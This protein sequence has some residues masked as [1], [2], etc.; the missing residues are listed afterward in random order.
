MMKRGKICPVCKKDIGQ[1]ADVCP[2]CGFDQ[3]NRI[4]LSKEDY[5]DWQK[6]K[7]SSQEKPKKETRLDVVQIKED[8]L[9]PLF[10]APSGSPGGY[11][12]C[13]RPGT[14]SDRAYRSREKQN[15]T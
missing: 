10:S 8:V 9:P 3:M 1:E 13:A 11:A 14:P 12:R 6:E 15:P 4:F 7:R 2:F 5:E